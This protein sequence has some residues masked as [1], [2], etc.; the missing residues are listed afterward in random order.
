MS[1]VN[2][3]TQD[4]RRVERF[5]AFLA[6]HSQV[7]RKHLSSTALTWLNNNND[8]YI[9]ALITVMMLID[10]N[11]HNDVNEDNNNDDEN[12]DDYD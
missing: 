8:N 10:D 7:Y 9:G 2:T 5:F 6:H 12:N 4:S 11:K 3:S 1:Y